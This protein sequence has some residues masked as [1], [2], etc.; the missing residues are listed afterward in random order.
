VVLCPLAH[1]APRVL[2]HYGRGE[3]GGGG[4]R[5]RKKGKHSTGVN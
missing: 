3:E 1:S 2:S 5:G 4:E